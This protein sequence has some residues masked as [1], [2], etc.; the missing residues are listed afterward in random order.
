MRF[1]LLRTH[2][3]DCKAAGGVV[4]SAHEVLRTAR[5]LPAAQC[6]LVHVVCRLRERGR[7]MFRA[8]LCACSQRSPQQNTCVSAGIAL[9]GR[10]SISPLENTCTSCRFRAMLDYYPFHLPAIAAVDVTGR[11][12]RVRSAASRSI[13]LEL[14]QFQLEG[15][16]H[17]RRYPH[18]DLPRCVCVSAARILRRSKRC[19]SSSAYIRIRGIV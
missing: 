8:E 1:A 10:A 11:G 3:P 18:L 13:E 2:L 14:Q 7:G 9:G 16:F 12:T 4:A 17:R 5:V 6:G 15:R 19:S